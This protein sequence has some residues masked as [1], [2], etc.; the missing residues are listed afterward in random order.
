MANCNR[1]AAKEVGS[2]RHLDHQ[3]MV[4]DKVREIFTPQALNKMFKPDFS[5]RKEDKGQEYSQEDK[6]FLQIVNQGTR[7]TENN[8][9]EIPLPFRCTDLRFPENKEQ[10]LQRAYWLKRRFNKSETF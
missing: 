10:V 8:H 1:V 4:E 7:H 2:D 9:Y 6:K 5:E 3:F